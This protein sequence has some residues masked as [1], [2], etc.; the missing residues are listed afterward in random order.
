MKQVYRSTVART[1][2]AVSQAADSM[3]RRCPQEARLPAT[4]FGVT[5]LPTRDSLLLSVEG[6]Q[7]RI[8]YPLLSMA[9]N[10]AVTS[11]LWQRRRGEGASRPLGSPSPRR[12]HT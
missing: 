1:R 2:S 5:M 10:C 9:R 6:V 3:Q 7:G 4:D 12:A 8:D 11:S